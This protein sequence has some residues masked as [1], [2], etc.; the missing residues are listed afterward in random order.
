MEA[1][2]AVL[3]ESVNYEEEYA[4]A[5]GRLAPQTSGAYRR[6]PTTFEVEDGTAFLLYAL[7]RHTKPSLTIE[8]GVAD[9][10]STRV[11]LSALDANA[12]GRLISVDISDDVGGSAAGHPRWSLRVHAPGRSSSRQLQSLLEE[13]GPPDLFFHD[14]S[15]TY[16]DQYADYLA[17]W[18]HTQPGSLFM[19]DDVDQSCAFGDLVT[20][21]G[22]KPVVLTERRKAAGVVLLPHERSDVDVS[23]SSRRVS[24]VRKS[25]ACEAMVKP[26]RSITRGA[27]RR[28]LPGPV[29]AALQVAKCQ[30]QVVRSIRPGRECPV[31]G[32]RLRFLV[33]NAT[34]GRREM[35]CMRCKS[36]ERHRRVVLFLRLRTDLYSESRKRLRVLHVAREAS[37]RA[38]ILRLG[39]I[40]YVT[41]DLLVGN[42]DVRLDLT[43]IDFPDAS[44]DV[45]LCS[46]VLEHIREDRKA[47]T[48]IRR[49]LR[50]D[51]WALINVPSDPART[52]TFEDMSIVLPQDRLVYFGQE[53]HVRVYSPSD[54]LG[55]LQAAGFNVNVDPV[56]FTLAQR[57]R[58]L[59]DGDA[60]WDHSYFVALIRRGRK[61][62]HNEGS[63]RQQM[64]AQPRC[65]NASCIWGSRS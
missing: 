56:E 31:C 58:Y 25:E 47:M 51:G 65:M 19:S 8:V 7:V 4:L 29:L 60:G 46:H 6:Y 64:I 28:R 9:G 17:A 55:R 63:R 50:G 44:F 57:R 38:E 59:L 30:V 62:F 40:D 53:D 1:A 26:G 18:Q 32:N 13:V 45:I 41:G 11:I 52:I 37:L 16:Y 2:Q 24:A 22:L 15:H 20:S 36:L 42:V 43:D 12:G 61:R 48:E 10:R 23:I 5:Q 3:G 34:G 35:L 54:V 49:V 33:V 21:C 39:G 14:A 27:L